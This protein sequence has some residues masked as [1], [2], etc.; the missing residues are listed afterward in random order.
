LSVRINKASEEQDD[1][2]RGLGSSISI[3]LV[4]SDRNQSKPVVDTCVS[5]KVA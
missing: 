4:E 5:D 3:V 1:G 2:R